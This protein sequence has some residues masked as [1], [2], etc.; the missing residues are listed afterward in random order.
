MTHQ[1]QPSQQQQRKKGG[2][3]G[4]KEIGKPQTQSVTPA[5]AA[6][7][8]AAQYRTSLACVPAQNGAVSGASAASGADMMG[9]TGMGAAGMGVTGMGGWPAGYYGGATNA[10]G[11]NPYD[12]TSAQQ[13]WWQQQKQKEM[14]EHQKREQY[15]W[16]VQKEMKIEVCMKP[17]KLVLIL[18]FFPV[19]FTYDIICVCVLF[20]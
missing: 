4:G 13:Q 18:V 1:Q 9:M 6:A 20:L 14:K 11:V 7:N 16:W 10:A 5:G 12:T 2:A 19:R 15:V 3:D 8:Y 17:C